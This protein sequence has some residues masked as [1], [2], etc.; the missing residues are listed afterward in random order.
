[1][2]LVIL[3]QNGHIKTL[4]IV[5]GVDDILVDS[6]L[7][8]H[9]LYL[10]CLVFIGLILIKSTPNYNIELYL[11]HIFTFTLKYI[12]ISISLISTYYPLYYIDNIYVLF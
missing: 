1:M 3:L 10:G 8:V 5:F 6:F 12:D 7:I 2:S 11:I 4:Y 9:I